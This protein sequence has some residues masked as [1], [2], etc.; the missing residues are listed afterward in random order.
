[1]ELFVGV[2]LADVGFSMN[3]YR[4]CMTDIDSIYLPIL[5]TDLIGWGL[6]QLFSFFS[7]PA[8]L[9]L[10]LAWVLACYYL[11]FLSWRLYKRYR[12][13]DMVLP[14]LALAV[15]LA[16]TNFNFFI[17]NT[18]V[19]L[20]ALTGLYFLVRGIN[21]KKPV[22]LALSSFFFV[23]AS[24]CKISALLQFGVFIVL[25]YEWYR[26]KD[27]VYFWKQILYVVLGFAAGLGVAA[28]ILQGTCG[29]GNYIDMVI[30][31]F[32]Y[33]GSSSD[34]HTIGNMVMINIKGAL[35]G[36]LLLAALFVG[37]FLLKKC[38]RL[39]WRIALV[40]AAA[41]AFYAAGVLTFYNA[42]SVLVALIYVC[43]IAVLRKR[44]YEKEYQLLVLAAGILTVLMPIGSNVGITHIC[45]EF[46]FA[47]PY[48]LIEVKEWIMQ[49]KKTLPEGL[50]WGAAAVL[51]TVS[52]VWV[53][54][55]SCYQ[56]LN[57][58]RAYS[59]KLADMKGYQLEDLAGMKADSYSVEQLEELIG[60]LRAYQEEDASLIAV[61]AIPLVN[62]LSEIRPAI[63]GCGGW[64]ETDYVTAQ[65][66]AA[67]LEGQNPI[68]VAKKAVWTQQ[69]EKTQV[70][71]AFVEENAYSEVFANEEYIVYM[72]ANKR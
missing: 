67:Q 56:S 61:G 62:E 51:V 20:M 40:L 11:C 17:Y 16:K 1:M 22:H 5:L 46:F 21:D 4:F 49:E 6:L 29:I 60:Y 55:L 34:G 64:I 71:A 54:S 2:D 14:A 23:L 45:N 36:V 65:E 13:D 35:R 33:A 38:R 50:R 8:Y 19:A 9:G 32:F 28:V 43:L 18:S 37:Y 15:L 66:I 24:L 63:A 59:G 58:T 30:Q 26:T 53:V 48:I 69:T 10:E 68:I 44:T 3:Q 7:I 72:Q 70:V 27:A 52:A 47:L 31:M 25:F 41:V 57:K 42:L 39:L 12:N